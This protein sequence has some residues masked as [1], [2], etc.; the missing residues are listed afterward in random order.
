[1]PKKINKAI[2][3][4]LLLPEHKVQ[5]FLS[6]KYMG[7]A[8]SWAD[9][10]ATAVLTAMFNHR[11]PFVLKISLRSETNYSLRYNKWC[12]L[13]ASASCEECAQVLAAME[14]KFHLILY[15][16]SYVLDV[17][18]FIPI[19]PIG[20]IKENRSICHFYKLVYYTP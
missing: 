12:T 18:N 16:M 13:Y 14:I 9:L 15:N 8:V 2:T 4:D 5:C 7:N 3:D 6:G 11:A 10:S 19:L 20:N 1:M 17:N